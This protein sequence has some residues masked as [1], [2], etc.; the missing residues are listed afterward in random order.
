[1]NA[2]LPYELVANGGSTGHVH[3]SETSV[4]DMGHLS[5]TGPRWSSLKGRESI[6]KT[7][8]SERRKGVLKDWLVRAYHAALR[9]STAIR[10]YAMC[11]AIQLLGGSSIK[12]Q[13]SYSAVWSPIIE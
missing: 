1:M 6:F 2:M 3:N 9:S 8:I 7:G 11:N 4:W 13:R 5:Q 12:L 10:R